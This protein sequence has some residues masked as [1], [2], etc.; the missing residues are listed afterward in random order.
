VGGN[1]IRDS[2]LFTRALAEALEEH[3]DLRLTR[4]AGRKERLALPS[5]VP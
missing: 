1:A 3:Q 5:I 2:G 4:R